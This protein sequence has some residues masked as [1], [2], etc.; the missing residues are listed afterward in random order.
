MKASVVLLNLKHMHDSFVIQTFTAL[1]VIIVTGIALILELIYF[2]LRFLN[3]RCY[4]N[5]YT[6][7]GI[8]V[9]AY[10][11]TTQNHVIHMRVMTYSGY[12]P[13]CSTCY[14]LVDW[15]CWICPRC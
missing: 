7:Y 11:V 3:I 4:N 14:M 13:L 15:L 8:L 6:V 9:R 10:T 12:R 5:C 2:V 1:W